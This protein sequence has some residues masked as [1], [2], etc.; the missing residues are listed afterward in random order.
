MRSRQPCV[1]LKEYEFDGAN[2]TRALFANRDPSSPIDE[3]PSLHEGATRRTI[4]VSCA[5]LSLGLR[6]NCSNALK[7]IRGNTIGSHSI[8]SKAENPRLTN[9]LAPDPPRLFYDDAQPQRVLSD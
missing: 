8:Q 4:D 3:A 5:P 6:N 7:E 9:Q 1:L 2:L